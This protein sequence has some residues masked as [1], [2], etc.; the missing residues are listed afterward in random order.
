MISTAHHCC[1]AIKESLSRKAEIPFAAAYHTKMS[2]LKSLESDV[3]QLNIE[4]DRSIFHQNQ[5]GAARLM[6][7]KASTDY[8]FITKQ[9][10][11][12]NYEHSMERIKNGLE[13]AWKNK[14]LTDFIQCT[15]KIKELLTALNMDLFENDKIIN[16]L[17]TAQ[18]VSDY[19]ISVLSHARQ[20]NIIKEEYSAATI[21]VLEYINSNYNKNPSIN[22]SLGSCIPAGC[23]SVKRLK[24][25]Q[26]NPLTSF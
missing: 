14:R 26:E 12:N 10:F 5:V 9:A 21:Y 13:E 4:L 17:Y 8:S 16:R 15:D 2:T 18:E 11:I 7:K 22:E 3:S 6:S 19:L 25:K 20:F 24:R 23:I 1:V